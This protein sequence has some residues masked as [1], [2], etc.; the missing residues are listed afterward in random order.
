M[1]RELSRRQL[2]AAAGTGAIGL[3]AGGAAVGYA[4]APDGMASAETVPFYGEHQ[5]G[6]GT[7]AQ[8]RLVF[9][10]FDTSVETKGELAAVMREWTAAALRMT[11]GDPVGAPAGDP[12]S[13][14]LDTGEALGLPAARLTLTFG[15]GDSVF[16][17]A[18]QDRF[19]LASRRPRG[20]EPIGVLPGDALEPARTGG[21]LCVQACADDPQVAFHAVR[22]LA[23]IGRG[24]VTM[25]WAQLGFGRTSST[26]STQETP[27][28]LQ[29]FKDGTNNVHGDDADAMS[30]F[31]W[32]G[33]EEPMEWLRGGSFLVARRIRMYIETWD[34]S[35]LSDQEAT[36]GREKLSG[37]P[38][39]G[40]AERDLVD[41]K[42]RGSDGKPVIPD[43][44]HIRLAAPASNGDERILRR[45][46]SYTD[47]IDP[48][49]G[50][51]DAGLFF[52][53]FNRDPKKQF[54]TIQGRLGE[55]DALREY[56]V[57]TGGG[58]FAVPPGVRPGG[59]VGERLLA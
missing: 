56:V 43:N 14:P 46:Y 23:R 13:P 15:F 3:A 11:A 49:T 22:N 54:A 21:D 40:T 25:R 55:F 19:G 6:I 53:C 44:A 37:A 32:L 12:Y 10:T 59:F 17:Q 38:L 8:D 36:I 30:R 34:R 47:G 31:V 39:G 1:A 52:V 57:H 27:R 42:A 18:G 16:L 58:L 35:T 2:L 51:L 24:A 41:L 50:E 7:A 20:L 33:D 29:G 4:L 28:N 48:V 5:A 45:G 9:A 26:Q